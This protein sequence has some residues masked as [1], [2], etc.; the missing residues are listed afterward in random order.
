MRREIVRQWVNRFAGVL[1]TLGMVAWPGTRVPTIGRV[2]AQGAPSVSSVID[3]YC[4]SCHD[5]RR[6]SPSGVVLERFDGARIAENRASWARAYRQ[7]QAGTMPPVDLPRPDR[8]T[9]DAVLAS[10]ELW[11]ADYTFLDEQLARHYGAADVAGSGFRRVRSAPERDGLLGQGSILMVTSRHNHGV[12]AAYTTPATRAKWVRLHFLGAPLPTGFP[13]AQ[14]V[15]PELPITPQTRALPTE[16]CVTCHRNFFPLGYALENF[17]PIGR[18]RTRDQLGPVDTSG[19]LVDG[20][21]TN[22]VIA[23][24]QALLQRPD[25]FRTTITEQ[26]LIY[27]SGGSAGPTG[28]TPDTLVRARQI[29]RRTPAPRWST[30]IAAAVQAKTALTEWIPMVE[31][32]ATLV[33]AETRRPAA[34]RRRTPAWRRWRW[35]SGEPARS[36]RETVQRNG[37]PAPSASIGWPTHRRLHAWLRP[38][39]RSSRGPVRRGT[40]IRSVRR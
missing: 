20:T 11:T 37:S 2:A 32:G 40:R 17:D 21:P 5:G 25:A 9:V 14:P 29:L 36:R 24:R 16:P 34:P 38:R 3:A 39:S 26:L 35:T 22:G 19:T 28:G 31:P 18:W 23:L 6:R 1:V 33:Q 13:G 4:V 27:S 8:A 30:L 12:D 15:K 7:L 10:I